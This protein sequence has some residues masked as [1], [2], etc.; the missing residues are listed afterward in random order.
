M[1][2]IRKNSGFTLLE[3][4]VV[5]LLLA[6]VVGLAS[7]R[8]LTNELDLARRE[9]LHFQNVVQWLA[10]QSVYTGDTYRLRLN[11][12][13]QEYA[14]LVLIDREFVVVID[15]LAKTR[16]MAENMVAMRWIPYEERVTIDNSELAFDFT[17][18]G[19]ASPI[20]VGFSPVADPDT[21]YSVFFSP[22][23]PRPLIAEGI[24][25]WSMIH[26]VTAENE[27]I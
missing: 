20:L 18:F 21:G 2:N 26:A 13:E 15:P 22:G 3:M 25:D 1:R 17:P 19:P 10:D 24:H 8:L 5:M 14:C 7:P 4:L 27:A 11:V 12:A 16:K 23:Q 9:A 6:L